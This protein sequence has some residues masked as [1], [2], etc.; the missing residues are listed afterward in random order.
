MS[1]FGK[2]EMTQLASLKNVKAED[3]TAETLAAVNA[4]L[5]EA[6]INAVEITVAGALEEASNQRNTAQESLTA[7]QEQLQAE[8][9]RATA[10]ETELAT[11][12]PA[13]GADANHSNSDGAADDKETEVETDPSHADAFN[14]SVNATVAKK[15]H[16]KM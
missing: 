7:A 14:A 6:G 13:S 16:V 9:E 10:L 1:L 3:V 11:Y 4:E 8:Q 15:Y 5:A 2:K 12:K